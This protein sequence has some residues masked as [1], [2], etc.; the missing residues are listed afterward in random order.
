MTRKCSKAIPKK[1]ANG[2]F[3]NPP[4][5]SFYLEGNVEGTGGNAWGSQLPDLRQQTQQSVDPWSTPLFN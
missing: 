2:K 1:V 4:K 3:R 5:D